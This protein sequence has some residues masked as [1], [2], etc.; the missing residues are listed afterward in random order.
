M[1]KKDEKT[2]AIPSGLI[3]RLKVLAERNKRS[4]KQHT[5]Y[6]LEQACDIEEKARRYEGQ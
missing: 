1:L 6:I 4:L 3:P 5:A 2:I